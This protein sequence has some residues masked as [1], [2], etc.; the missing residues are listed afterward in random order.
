[1]GVRPNIWRFLSKKT[2]IPDIYLIKIRFKA[3]LYLLPPCHL[4]LQ[5]ARTQERSR[6]RRPS[7][8]RSTSPP[9]R[10]YSYT[11]GFCY[12][13]LT[14]G[15]GTTCELRQRHHHHRSETPL[16]RRHQLRSLRT[17]ADLLTSVA[18]D[19]PGHTASTAEAAPR[20]ASPAYGP[21]PQ[22]S[23]VERRTD[24]TTA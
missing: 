22:P 17:P 20:P 16:P 15:C 12:T 23:T 3:V 6:R 21:S 19:P 2:R 10:S 5:S 8:S 18:T 13:S 7:P 24:T 4:C 1:M 14:E 9:P 11:S